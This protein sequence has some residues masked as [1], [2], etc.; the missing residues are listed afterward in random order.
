M[1]RLALTSLKLVKNAM[2]WPF[3]QDG[4][5]ILYYGNYLHFSK[6]N[7][8]L[9]DLIGQEQSYAGGNDPANREA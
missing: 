7:I 4:I 1:L 3:I 5:P 2:T 8:I 6:P 9:M